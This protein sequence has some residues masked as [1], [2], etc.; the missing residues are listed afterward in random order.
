MS[1]CLADCK[2]LQNLEPYEFNFVI[3]DFIDKNNFLY[4]KE[5]IKLNQKILQELEYE[6]EEI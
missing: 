5:V 6:E 4:V 1:D 3:S 2:W